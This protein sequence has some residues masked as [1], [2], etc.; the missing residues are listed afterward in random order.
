MAG[1][2]KRLWGEDEFLQAYAPP[3]PPACSPGDLQKLLDELERMEE[4]CGKFLHV[5]GGGSRGG[6]SSGRNDQEHVG[7][8]LI[9]GGRERGDGGAGKAS[10]LREKM[11]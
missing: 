3:P 9:D 4:M 11:I 6:R 1:R 8:T 10:A 7:K 5:E 2:G